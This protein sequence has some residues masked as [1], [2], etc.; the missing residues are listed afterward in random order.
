MPNMNRLK[1]FRVYFLSRLLA[2]L[3]FAGLTLLLFCAQAIAPRFFFAGYA[4][5]MPMSP[6]RRQR[7]CGRPRQAQSLFALYVGRGP[8][9]LPASRPRAPKSFGVAAR[10]A[11]VWVLDPRS[12]R[13]PRAFRWPASLRAVEFSR[14]GNCFTLPPRLPATHAPGLDAQ[15]HAIVARAATGH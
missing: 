14:D 3:A 8:F 4:A 7:H 12:T 1:N 13:S 5:V 10:A 6:P 15:S 11:T 2:A 9:R